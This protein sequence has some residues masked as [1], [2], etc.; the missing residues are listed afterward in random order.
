MT[1]KYLRSF[2]IGSSCLVFLPYFY[3]VSKF[4]PSKFNF[5]YTWYTF[6]AP[7][8]LGLMNLASLIIAEKFSIS[9]S[10]RFL[11]ASIIAPTLVLATVMFF[12]IYNY[13]TEDW[14]SHIIGLYSMY[15]VVFNFVLY[16]LDK[17]V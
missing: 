16:Y 2:V 3:V 12:K 1:N 6:I 15:F 8:G 4:N 13:T 9:N 5:D 14:I 11:Y 17:Y 7:I 10:N